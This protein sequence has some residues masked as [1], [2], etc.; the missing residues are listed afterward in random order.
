VGRR[1]E[2]VWAH[3]AVPDRLLLMPRALITGVTGQDGK[4]LSE[5][6]LNKGYEVYGMVNGQRNDDSS[7]LKDEIPDVIQ[8][9][10]DLTDSSSLV[11]VLD[12]TRPDEIY[13][14]GAISFVG[15][16]FQQ[17]EL[18]AN[19]TGLG[20]LR[21]LEAIRATKMDSATKIY[22]AS[23]SEMFGKVQQV[24]QNEST[25]FYPRSPYGVSKVFA[26]QAC[27]NYREAYGMHISCGILF[28]HEGE[29]RGPEF[30]T[31]K[32]SQGVARISLGVE[33]QISLGDLT[34]KRD[35]GYAGDY[36][37]AMWLMLQQNDPD[38]YVIATGETHSV[39]EFITEALK[40]A[41]LDGKPEDYVKQDAK[42]MR[43]SEVHLLVGDASKA[44]EKL[45]W[46]PKVHF[47]E[48]VKIMVNHDIEAES[49]K[50]G[51]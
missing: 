1:F 13:N 28:N 42:F 46:I 23:S 22:Q 6:L 12:E 45:G 41:N 11:R 9:R 20:V 43:P 10:G 4:H 51:R 2:P 49:R 33:S 19:I 50:L 3:L 21:L 26:H 48:L 40:A 47:E 7:L 37:E 34:P 27:V 44:R 25:P 17:P 24:P 30:V 35:W 8:V 36:V 29:R 18:T 5:L 39:K 32:I 15:M 31:R 14:L 16:S 38:D